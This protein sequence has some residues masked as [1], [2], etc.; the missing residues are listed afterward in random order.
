MAQAAALTG[1]H[2]SSDTRAQSRYHAL[3]VEDM[4]IMAKIMGRA[5]D[6][7]AISYEHVKNGKEATAAM[8]RGCFDMVF[9]DIMMPVM[10]GVEATRCIRATERHANADAIP[11]IAVTT[12]MSDAECISYRDAGM[13]DCIKKPVDKVSLEALLSRLLPETQNLDVQTAEYYDVL[14]DD[15]E[16]INWDTLHEYGTLFKSGLVGL[17]DDYLA[18][19]PGLME[20]L[21]TAIQDKDAYRIHM[22]ASQFKSASAVFGAD[23]V[24]HLAARMEISAGKGEM[25]EARELYADLHLAYERTSEAL[26]KK[27]VVLKIS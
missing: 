24:S 16:F 4:P 1:S 15:M 11:I 12:K 27:L 7:L 10:D 25:A 14:A 8:A 6:A 19:A 18:A 20:M 9:M 5:L 2:G 13:T 22:F 23:R 17:I 3:L 21:S 26:R